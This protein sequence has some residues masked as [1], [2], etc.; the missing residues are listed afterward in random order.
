MKSS[1]TLVLSIAV[2]AMM[3]LAVTN[4]LA[5][6]S[7]ASQVVYENDFEKTVG[8]EWSLPITDTTPKGAR[9]F[10]GQFGRETVKAE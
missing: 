9:G 4:T 3:V 2:V 10:L 1:K 8:R 7:K 6:S 5:K